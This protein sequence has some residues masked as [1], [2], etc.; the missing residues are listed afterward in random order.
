MGKEYY[1]RRKKAILF[2]IIVLLIFLILLGIINNLLH[3][4]IS[5][6]F[7]VIGVVVNLFVNSIIPSPGYYINRLKFDNDS[8]QKN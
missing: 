6:Y 8:I 3:L 4:N 7:I 5:I 1:D 2:N